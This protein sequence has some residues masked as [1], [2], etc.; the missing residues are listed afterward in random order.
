MLRRKRAQSEAAPPAQAEMPPQ[1]TTRQG[2][3]GYVVTELPTYWAG[4]RRIVV[5]TSAPDGRIIKT[6]KK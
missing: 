5:Y 4:K 3:N 1:A 2:P 6:F